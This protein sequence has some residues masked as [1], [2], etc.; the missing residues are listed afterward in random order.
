MPAPYFPVE[1]GDFRLSMGL[2]PLREDSWIEIDDHYEADLALK[3]E[4][5]NNQRDSIVASIP[6]AHQAE[7]EA[8]ELTLQTLKKYFP[9]RVLQ[10][11]SDTNPLVQ[12]ALLVQEDLVIMQASENGFRLSSAVVCFPSASNLAEKVGRD[13]RH[14]HEPVPG[15]NDQIGNSIDLFFSNMKHEKIVVRYN[16]GLYDSDQL[17]QPGWLRNR[18]KRP[19]ITASNIGEQIFLRVEK[20]TLQRLNAR[21]DALFSIR[22]FNTPLSDAVAQPENTKLLLEAVTSMPDDFRKYK[23]IEPYLPELVSYLEQRQG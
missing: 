1:K 4:L 8:L 5:V 9:E 3:A 23:S 19:T 14:I 6:S 21:M 16:W 2:R 7:Q 20:Q 12:A 11:V 17:F 10:P 13:M 22:I 15:L 18:Q